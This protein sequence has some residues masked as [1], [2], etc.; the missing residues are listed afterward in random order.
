MMLSIGSEERPYDN[1]FDAIHLLEPQ[2]IILN[3]ETQ[4]GSITRVQRYTAVALDDGRI[5]NIAKT[6]SP[7][8]YRGENNIFP[9]CKPS[10]YRINDELERMVAEIRAIEFI[11]FLKSLPEIQALERQNYYVAYEAL[12]QHYGF[13]T[14]VLDL[15]DDLI[16]AAFFATHALNPITMRMEFLKEGIGQI[17]YSD[18][19]TLGIDR[20]FFPIGLQPLARPAAQSGYGYYMN[21]NDDFAEFSASIFFYQNADKNQKL[22]EGIPD[23]ENVFLPPER[24]YDF[25]ANMIKEYQVLYSGS[26]RKYCDKHKVDFEGAVGRLQGKYEIVDAPIVIKEMLS[27]FPIKADLA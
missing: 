13:A 5:V 11:D 19:A 1:I 3:A 8:Y 15:T 12:A 16:T 25:V 27:G 6:P 24:K 21:A 20:K 10:V 22:A 26:L 17:R 4:E 7:F 9:T 14:N 23:A 18:A 2:N